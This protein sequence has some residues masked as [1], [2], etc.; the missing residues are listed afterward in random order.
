MPLRAKRNP[1][2][3]RRWS[4]TPGHLH[5]IQMRCLSPLL[6]SWCL[7]LS[8]L[9]EGLLWQNAWV[10]S[11]PPGTE[12]AAAYGR[13]TND[14]DQTVVITAIS[15]S[16]GEV[17]QI[18]DVIAD[19]DQRRM[20]QLDA[21]SLAAGESTEFKPGGQHIML[22]GV[23]APPP[24]GSQ[25]ELCLLTANN[26]ERCTSVPVQRQAPMPAAEPSG[27]HH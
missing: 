5:N 17:A 13:V 8:A 7:P 14:G 2:N 19:G 12:V 21:V 23:T 16:V 22:L 4:T 27:H 6:L 24:E 26:A 1:K 18:H 15:S 25:V 9:A 11:M 10:R 3:Q 20:V